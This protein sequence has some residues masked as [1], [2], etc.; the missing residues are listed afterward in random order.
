MSTPDGQAAARHAVVIAELL[1]GVR[2]EVA[3]A[4]ALIDIA[5]D[6]IEQP[7]ATPMP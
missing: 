4:A 6:E 3:G 1:A 5:E 2:E 7:V